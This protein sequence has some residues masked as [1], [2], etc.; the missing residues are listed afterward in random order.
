MVT[1]NV[2]SEPLSLASLAT[3]TYDGRYTSLLRTRAIQQ[4]LTQVVNMYLI[5]VLAYWYI[6][7]MG[8]SHGFWE[9]DR[10]AC[11]PCDQ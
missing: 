3:T 9:A 8:I 10:A 7:D 5:A 6:D 4:K 1:F 2:D 11:L